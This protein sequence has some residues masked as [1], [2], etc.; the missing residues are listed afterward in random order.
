[1]TTL[2]GSVS[3]NIV[4]AEVPGPAAAAGYA[5]RMFGPA[6]WVGQNWGNLVL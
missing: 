4:L 1:M 6:V 5:S 3:T 2:V